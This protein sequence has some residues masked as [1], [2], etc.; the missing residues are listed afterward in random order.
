[1]WGCRTVSGFFLLS[2]D[3]LSDAYTNSS[4]QYNNTEDRGP[5]V[6]R[7][8]SRALDVWFTLGAAYDQTTKKF[9]ISPIYQAQLKV[10]KTFAD[11]IQGI[12]NKY[13]NKIGTYHVMNQN[14]KVNWPVHFLSWDTIYRLHGNYGVMGF[15]YP[16]SS[17]GLITY[18]WWQGAFIYPGRTAQALSTYLADFDSSIRVL[19]AK[20]T[21]N[22]QEL[23]RKEIKRN[24]ATNFE[25]ANK[26]FPREKIAPIGNLP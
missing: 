9:D 22:D 7:D 12:L 24:T 5:E 3:R 1:M 20:Y 21:N 2:L 6:S 15:N 23:L 26:K 13:K 10:A 8:G 4:R 11:S 17:G 16:V 25:Q 18:Q 19:C 14:L